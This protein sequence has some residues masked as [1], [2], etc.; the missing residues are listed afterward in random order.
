MNCGRLHPVDDDAIL[1]AMRTLRGYLPGLVGDAEAG[2][3][4]RELAD[5]LVSTADV[6]EVIDLG[7]QVL[8]RDEA[9][10]E[11]AAAFLADGFP[12]DVRALIEERERYS[13]LPGLGEPPPAAR[14]YACPNGDFVRWR[15]G[16]EPL[17][18]CP[19]HSLPLAEAPA[20]VGDP[21]C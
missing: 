1:E 5:L 11:W 15:R 4:D 6:A 14:R 10:A 9:V 20:G 18:P 7:L 2:G 12:P 8:Q 16:A 21:P 17:P 13:G 19:T 3:I